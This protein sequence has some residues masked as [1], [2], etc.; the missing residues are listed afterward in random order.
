LAVSGA[1]DSRCRP[2]GSLTH[3]SAGG[4]SD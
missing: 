4:D 1:D 3:S 2:G